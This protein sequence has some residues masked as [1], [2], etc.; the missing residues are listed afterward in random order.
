MQKLYF[1]D[2]WGRTIS[3]EDR[4][5]IT[6]KFDE[7]KLNLHDGVHFTFLWDAENHENETLITTLIH[8]VQSHVLH[9]DDTVI[10]YKIK[11]EVLCTNHF[12]VKEAISAHSSMPWTFIFKKNE[13]VNAM[14]DYSI[15]SK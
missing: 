4:D 8:N 11:G 12:H 7:I 5:R 2:A 15:T 13:A 9:L 6:E 1:E 3:Q 14:P 10:A